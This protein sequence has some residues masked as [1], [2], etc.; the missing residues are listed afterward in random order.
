[1]DLI[2][3][4]NIG[5]YGNNYIVYPWKFILLPHLQIYI[6]PEDY[7]KYSQSLEES[8][9]TNGESAFKIFK[10]SLD[11][12]FQVFIGTTK[13]LHEIFKA[14]IHIHPTLKFTMV[15]TSVNKQ[16]RKTNVIVQELPQYHFWTLHKK[17]K[18]V[19]LT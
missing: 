9:G 11:D 13:Q 8:M 17:S 6:W 3:K 14:I 15:H 19:K 1:M 12:L 7:I 16:Q 4:Y 5:N 10:R 2:Q 18:T